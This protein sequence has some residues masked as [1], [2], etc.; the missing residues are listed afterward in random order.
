MEHYPLNQS[1]SEEQAGKDFA[2]ERVSADELNSAI[3]FIIAS[4]CP[5]SCEQVTCWASNVDNDAIFMSQNVLG[6]FIY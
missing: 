4:G 1:V 6:D 5:N 2:G 3:Q